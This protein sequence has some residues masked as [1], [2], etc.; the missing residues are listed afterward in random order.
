MTIVFWK[1]DNCNVN[2][3]IVVILEQE[4]LLTIS[5]LFLHKCNELTLNECS[6]NQNDDKAKST[7]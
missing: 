1:L 6:R 7:K 2:F 5:A 3:Y 4:A